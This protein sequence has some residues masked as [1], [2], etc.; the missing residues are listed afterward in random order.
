MLLGFYDGSGSQEGARIFTLCG[1]VAEE[2]VWID[3]DSRWKAVLDNPKWPTRV[4][5]FHTYDCV[6]GDGEFQRPWLYAERLTMFGEL[7]D[8]IVNSSVLALGTSVVIEHLNNLSQEDKALLEFHDFGTPADL[9][10]QLTLQFLAD[11]VNQSGEKE[12]VAVI[13]DRENPSQAERY[14]ALYNR[15]EST[16]RLRRHF[17]GMA[18]V[19]SVDAAPIQAADILAYATMRL[20]RD[21]FYPEEREPWFPIIPAFTRMIEGINHDGGGYSSEALARLI[22]S[23]RKVRTALRRSKPR[24]AL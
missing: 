10:F 11:K 6:H 13:C 8:V 3:F 22:E 18:F 1:F 7:V 9:A 5:E 17:A 21:R 12:R 19:D 16:Y 15:Y 2:S 4:S 23:M 24:S 20:E 14:L